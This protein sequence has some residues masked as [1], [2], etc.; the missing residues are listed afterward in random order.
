MDPKPKKLS[1][2][3]NEWNTDEVTDA[4]SVARNIIIVPGTF[5]L[6]EMVKV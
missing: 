2:V 4:L 1:G 6:L 5:S 3:H